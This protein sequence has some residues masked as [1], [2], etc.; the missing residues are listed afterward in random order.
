MPPHPTPIFTAPNASV[1][2]EVVLSDLDTE[3]EGDVMEIQQQMDAEKKRLED[4]VKA[5]IVELRE[6]K[7]KEKAYWKRQEVFDRE[8]KE[9]ETQ[10]EAERQKKAD[11][12]HLRKMIQD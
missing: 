6:K 1:V 7:W 9:E 4:D 8:R 2:L 11:L 12:K 5:W 3:S 10:K